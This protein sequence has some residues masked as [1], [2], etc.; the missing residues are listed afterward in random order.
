MKNVT[1]ATLSMLLFS[2]A[3]AQKTVYNEKGDK[4][5][6]YSERLQ[7]KFSSSGV[8]PADT[9]QVR[10]FAAPLLALLPTVVDMAF[11]FTNK[12]IEN[13]VKKYSAEYTVSQSNIEPKYKLPNFTVL[14]T[15]KIKSDEEQNLVEKK[16]LKVKFK[17][18]PVDGVGFIYYIE[19]LDVGYSNA[20]TRT[21]YNTLDYVFEIKPQLVVKGKDGT[22]ETKVLETTPIVVSS[23]PM[24]GH[25][26]DSSYRTSILAV[27]KGSYISGMTV[28]IIETN[29]YKVRAEKVLNTWNDQKDNVKTIINNFLPEAKKE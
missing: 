21:N 5:K 16:A 14:R 23:V 6:F 20:K 18:L 12:A 19:S 25:K 28:K 17:V 24:G 7:I 2:T 26:L 9:G 22:S 4:K 29:P 10:T 3:Q 11:K 1:L 27:P 8:E 13:N 15:I